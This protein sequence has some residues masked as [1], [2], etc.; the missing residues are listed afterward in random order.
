M[1]VLQTPSNSAAETE[2]TY[3]ASLWH[4]TVNPS[5]Q[6]AIVTTTPQIITTQQ[7]EIAVS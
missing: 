3:I 6:A 1:P 5:Q 4:P 7:T 2:A